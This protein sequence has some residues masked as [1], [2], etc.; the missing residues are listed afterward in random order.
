MIAAAWDGEAAHLEAVLGHTE[1]DFGKTGAREFHD[2][3]KE[4]GSA[5]ADNFQKLD[6][7]THSL[8]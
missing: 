6:E 1:L 5:A 4:D 2:G 7:A 3:I 8:K